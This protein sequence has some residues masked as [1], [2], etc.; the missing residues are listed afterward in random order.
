[1]VE[2]DRQ[3]R[4]TLAT[5][6]LFYGAASLVHFAHNAEFL[7]DY[8]NL[9][10]SWTRAGIYGGWIWLTLTGIGGWIL[11]VGG[12]QIAGLAV[13]AVYAVLGMDSLGHY[14][15]APLG[16]HT[17]GMNATIL[18]EVGAATLVLFAVVGQIVRRLRKTHL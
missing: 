17:L 14:V 5:L 7:A 3:A 15:L 13:L 8:P 4:R 11:L 12:F 6:L 1:M 18:L 16:A 10:A 9:P 2:M